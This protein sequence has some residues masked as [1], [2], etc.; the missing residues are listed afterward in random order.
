MEAGRYAAPTSSLADLGAVECQHQ[1]T[2]DIGP[3]AIASQITH[4]RPTRSST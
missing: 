2:V 4:Q 1:A 3:D